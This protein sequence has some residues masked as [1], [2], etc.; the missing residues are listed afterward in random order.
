MKGD[1]CLGKHERKQWLHEED[2]NTVDLTQTIPLV[3]PNCKPNDEGLPRLEHYK[4]CIIEGLRRGV[5]KQM[6]L[7]TV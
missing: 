5:A 1:Q 6:S 4:R 3:K 2:L 7:N